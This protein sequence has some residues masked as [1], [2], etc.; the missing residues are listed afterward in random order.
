MDQNFSL[1]LTVNWVQVNFD[2][3]GLTVIYS[4]FFMA[5]FAFL[6]NKVQQRRNQIERERTTTE[7][8]SKKIRKLSRFQSSVD[9]LHKFGGSIMS[10]AL[11]VKSKYCISPNLVKNA[12]IYLTKKNEILRTRILRTKLKVN[13]KK[14]MEKEWEFMENQDFAEFHLKLKAMTSD[15]WLTVFER[16]LTKQFPKEGPLWRF[17]MLKEQ[18]VPQEGMYSHAF[19]LSAH[20]LVCD[21]YSGFAFFK[22]FLEFVNLE[23]CGETTSSEADTNVFNPALSQLMESHIYMLLL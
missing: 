17:V 6:N 1:W 9:H 4:L 20:Q 15:Q 11:V 5:I 19:V 10:F 16:E 13:G 3:L 23:L 14:R 12:L 22:D 7:E 8:S 21:S 2:Q 18:F